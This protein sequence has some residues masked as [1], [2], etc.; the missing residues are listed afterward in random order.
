MRC[1]KCKW[2]RKRFDEIDCSEDESGKCHRF[3]PV[4]ITVSQLQANNNFR[5]CGNTSDFFYQPVTEKDDWCGEFTQAAPPN[6]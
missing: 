1:D 3:P 6:P 5:I 4:H 2:W